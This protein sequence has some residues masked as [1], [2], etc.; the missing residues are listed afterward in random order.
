MSTGKISFCAVQVSVDPSI[1]WRY[2]SHMP[3]RNPHP[4]PP[5]LQLAPDS[6]EVE[7]Q[8]AIALLFFFHYPGETFF[9]TPMLTIHF[10]NQQSLLDRH[11]RLLFLLESR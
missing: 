3:K 2:P 5:N 6:P 7:R 9:R 11:R 10:F 4:K 8:R 1:S